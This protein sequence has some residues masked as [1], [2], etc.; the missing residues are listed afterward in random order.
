M[1]TLGD[2][3]K[4]QEFRE[5]L[6]CFIENLCS[7]EDERLKFP[8]E[9]ADEV[10]DIMSLL[11]PHCEDCGAESSIGSGITSNGRFYPLCSV[12][13]VKRTSSLSIGSG[14]INGK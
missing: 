12:C 8:Y 4:D 7:N 14:S 2:R 5:R 3:R 10:I 1:Y 11:M 6:I 13:Q 9:L